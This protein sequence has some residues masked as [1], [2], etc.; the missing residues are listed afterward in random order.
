M[1]SMW[2]TSGLVRVHR[3]AAASST[4]AFQPGHRGPIP[5]GASRPDIEMAFPGWTVLDDQAADASGMPDR[6]KSAA[7]RWYRLRRD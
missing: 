6:L 5:R 1:R 3:T 7:P 4:L 2:W